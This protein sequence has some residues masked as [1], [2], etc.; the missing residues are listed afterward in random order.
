MNTADKKKVKGMSKE[1]DHKTN[2]AHIISVRMR[3]NYSILTKF[4]KQ[5]TFNIKH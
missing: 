4:I 5:L 1:I 2:T 3:E